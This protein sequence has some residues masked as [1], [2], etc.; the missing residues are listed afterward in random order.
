ML[1]WPIDGWIKPWT[2]PHWR[3]RVRPGS[4]EIHR[5]IFKWVCKRLLPG[6]PWLKEPIKRLSSSL[7]A[8]R[9]IRDEKER[10]MIAHGQIW[11]AGFK[12]TPCRT[13]SINSNARQ[14]DR[15]SSCLALFG[16]VWHIRIPNS[17]TSSYPRMANRIC[18][19]QSHGCDKSDSLHSV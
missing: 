14:T 8:S 17:L 12:C 13:L 15:L 7:L 6:K 16:P 2:S 11:A 10:I 18:V 19:R 3:R 1:L 5:P 4:H 9:F